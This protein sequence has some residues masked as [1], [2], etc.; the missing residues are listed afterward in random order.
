MFQ[1]EKERANWVMEEDH[2][3]RKTAESEDYI[4]SLERSKDAFRKENEKLRVE[5]KALNGTTGNGRK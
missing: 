4:K 1:I 5:L 3:R 2:F